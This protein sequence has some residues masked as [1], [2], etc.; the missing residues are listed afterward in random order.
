[1]SDDLSDPI[2]RINVQSDEAA[3][4]PFQQAMASLASPPIVTYAIVIANVAVFIVMVAR[5][6]SMTSPDTGTMLNWGANFGPMTMNGQW[7]RLLS[8]MFLHFGIVHIGLN[9]W[10]LWGLAPLVERF[11]GRT[12]FAIAYVMSGVAGGIASLAW[13]PSSVS[14]GA[15]GAVFGTAG[16]LLGFVLLR[17]DTIP[18]GVRNQMLKSM[19]K[20]LV[21]NIVIGMSV[22]AIDMAAHIGGFVGGI[23]FGLM[24]SQPVSPA[25][26]R[27]RKFKNRIAVA[28]AGILF[29]LAM[30]ALPAAPLDIATEMQRLA[31]VENQIYDTYNAAQQLAVR[32][33]IDDVELADQIELKVLAPWTKLREEVEGFLKL[34]Y[35]NRDYLLELIR[36]L[37]HRQES[38]TVLVQSLREQ[39]EAKLQRSDELRRE[40]DQM[41]KRL[42]EKP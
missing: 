9:M 38:W 25:M 41:R 29:P 8:Y 4:L 22:P 30:V 12:G 6:A 16:A 14:A 13:N 28:I 31:Q 3:T 32:G 36:Y 40:S 42:S 37:Q 7:W 17:S 20:F 23:V 11:L 21:L 5:G 19:S 39:D 18:S 34:K 26:I 15:S 33:A 2:E 24:L 35:A 10:V 1:M 27:R